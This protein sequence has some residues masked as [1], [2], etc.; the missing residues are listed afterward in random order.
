M[1]KLAVH[2]TKKRQRKWCLYFRTSSKRQTNTTIEDL[3]QRPNTVLE[4]IIV[5]QNIDA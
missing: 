1:P 5:V 4:T 3:W 2:V